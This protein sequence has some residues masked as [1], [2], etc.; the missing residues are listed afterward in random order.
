MKLSVLV[1]DN[2][3]DTG[4]S[5][6]L[7]AFTTANELAALQDP[8]AR[9]F[10]ITVVGMKRQV[11]TALGMRMSVQPANAA[12]GSDWI[13]VPALSTKLPE[14]LVPALGRRDVTDAMGRLRS[15]HADGSRVAASC[16]GT[17]LVA[18]SGLLRDQEAT[19]SW[20]LGPLFRQRYP[21]I[22]LDESRMLVPSGDFV[23]AG[24]AMGH[25]G[26]VPISWTP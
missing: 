6:V 21:E 1:L 3:F 12:D 19:T 17:F 20:W 4:L 14:Q 9:P 22:R 16:I 15:W 13:V 11:R 25:L 5:A 26:A 7:D 2:V 8:H 10:D 18:E 23:T 24:A